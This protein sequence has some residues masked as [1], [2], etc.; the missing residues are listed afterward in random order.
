[1]TAK[2][3][4][5]VREAAKAYIDK[6]LRVMSKH[7]LKTGKVSK[8]DYNAMIDEAAQAAKA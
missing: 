6:Q 5:D 7:G 2:K 1:M 4:Q 8:T 3:K